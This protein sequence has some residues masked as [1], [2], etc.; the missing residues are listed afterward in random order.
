[1]FYKKHCDLCLAPGELFCRI[2]VPSNSTKTFNEKQV[3]E[4]CN[5]NLIPK[6]KSPFRPHYLYNQSTDF[7]KGPFPLGNYTLFMMQGHPEITW[8]KHCTP[9]ASSHHLHQANVYWK[10]RTSK[11][12]CKPRRYSF[13]ISMTILKYRTCHYLHLMEET[14][15]ER[16]WAICLWSEKLQN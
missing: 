11:H 2:M 13:T 9:T 10:L 14:T 12:G 7:Q 6:W 5:L 15:V 3:M 1:M 16:D 4:V 8:S